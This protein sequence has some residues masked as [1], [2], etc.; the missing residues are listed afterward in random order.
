MSRPRDRISW[1]PDGKA[2][3]MA[4]EKVKC[5]RCDGK[6][7]WHDGIDWNPCSYCNGKGHNME[8]RYT[9]VPEFDAPIPPK[10]WKP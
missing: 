3:H 8:P 7:R 2:V 4:F 10:S 9:R 6:S 1:Q 5:T